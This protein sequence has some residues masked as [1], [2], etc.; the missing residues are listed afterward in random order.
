MIN[1]EEFITKLNS[2]MK[3]QLQINA[4]LVLEIN[5]LKVD[6]DKLNKKLKDKDKVIITGR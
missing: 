1:L 3:D 2:Y 5:N 4:R 6:I